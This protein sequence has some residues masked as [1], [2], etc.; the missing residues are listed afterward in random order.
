[1]AGARRLESSG[2]LPQLLRVDV[3]DQR[4]EQ[5]EAADQDLQKAVD[6]GVVETVV[7]H[8]QDEEAQDRVADAAAAAEQAGAADHDRGDRI[9]KVVVELVL[10]RAAEVSDAQDAR[11]TGAKARDDEDG[12]DGGELDPPDPDYPKK[13]A[14][15]PVA[16]P[17]GA[18]E[19]AS[20]SPGGSNPFSEE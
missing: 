4:Q 8:A 13:V 1:M 2:P 3:D 16:E 5:D 10:L 18:E 6:V 11:H 14:M 7:E 17:E 19:R 15:Y 9:Q 12:D 20:R